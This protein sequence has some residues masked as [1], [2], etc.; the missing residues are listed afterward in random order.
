MAAFLPTRYN[1]PLFLNIYFLSAPLEDVTLLKMFFIKEKS[2]YRGIL[3]EY[4][5]GA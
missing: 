2:I 4:K 1:E 5:S 3:L